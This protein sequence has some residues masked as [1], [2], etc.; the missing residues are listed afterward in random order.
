M[1]GL[2]HLNPRTGLRDRSKY[3]AVAFTL[4]ELLVVIAIIG[5]LVALLLPAVQAAREAARRI[6][7]TNQI[8]QLALSVLNHESAKGEFPPGGVAYGRYG[9]LNPD[10]IPFQCTSFDCNGTNWAV[11]ILPY[12]EQQ[13]LYDR[14]D[15]KE[16][17]FAVGDPN[18]N[19]KINQIVRDTTLPEMICPSDSY[20]NGDWSGALAVGSYKA[21]AGVITQPISGSGWI[22]WTSPM[23]PNSNPKVEVVLE[24]FS[25]RGFALFD[26]SAGHASRKIQKRDRRSQPHADDRRVSLDKRR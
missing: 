24:N 17:N 9:L 5:V 15:H 8:K 19:G 21:M 10:Q 22:N 18:G 14:Y 3:R 1:I 20:A 7:C 25:K 12:L 13:A 4:V 23:G 2:A 26:G 11:E 6:Q 16:T